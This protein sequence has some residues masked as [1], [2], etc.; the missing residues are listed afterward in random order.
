[1]PTA[2]EI[3][4]FNANNKKKGWCRLG[5][6]FWFLDNSLFQSILKESFRLSVQLFIRSDSVVY[7]FFFQL[8]SV[9][10][11][12]LLTGWRPRW[13]PTCPGPRESSRTIHSQPSSPAF[14][15]Q[16]G[17]SCHFFCRSQNVLVTDL[18]PHYR[19]SPI[20]VTTASGGLKDLTC[21]F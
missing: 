5:F 3:I 14:Q 20:S 4:E 7:S 9:A 15:S 19:R 13:P 8:R 10:T 6:P 1:M 11:T 21:K 2:D 18:F 16:V 12:L 17:R